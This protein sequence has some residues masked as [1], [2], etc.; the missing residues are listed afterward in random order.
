[1]GKSINRVKMKIK[2]NIKKMKRIGE[3]KK[4]RDG[5]F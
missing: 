2:W 5:I 4:V 3:E 1:M